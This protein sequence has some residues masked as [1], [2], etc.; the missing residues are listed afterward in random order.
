[1]N[2]KAPFESRKKRIL[3]AI[4]KVERKRDFCTVFPSIQLQT[5]KTQVLGVPMNKYLIRKQSYS[6]TQ[7]TLILYWI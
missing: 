6:K 5:Y 3:L 4:G 1:M 7:S 2:A